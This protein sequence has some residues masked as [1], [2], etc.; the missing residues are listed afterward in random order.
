MYFQ[1]VEQIEN[2]ENIEKFECLVCLAE[3]PLNRAIFC[4]SNPVGERR[5][6]VLIDLEKGFLLNFFFNLIKKNFFS[7]F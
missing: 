4:N 7:L 1:N 6:N 2:I 3:F 5:K